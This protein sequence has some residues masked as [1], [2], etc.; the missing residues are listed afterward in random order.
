M[1]PFKGTSGLNFLIMLGILEEN[2][3][4]CTC[5]LD[6]SPAEHEME[7]LPRA[8]TD[9]EEDEVLRTIRERFSRVRNSPNDGIPDDTLFDGIVGGSAGCVEK[10]K[11]NGSVWG[12]GRGRGPNL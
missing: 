10:N 2:S 6:D 5:F 12:R 1:H 11:R 9:L 3:M 7:I 8:R 4:L